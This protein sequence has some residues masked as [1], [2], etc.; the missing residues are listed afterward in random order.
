[1]AH[2]HRALA[3]AFA[4]VL[5]TAMTAGCLSTP[6]ASPPAAPHT[7]HAARGAPVA[8]AQPQA[9]LYDWH[10]LIPVPFGTLLKDMPI[11]LTEVLI[12]H[13]SAQSERGSED[14]DCYTTE[15]LSQPAF[16]G[17]EPDDH[18]L[19]FDHD[20]L[21]RIQISVSVP[22]AD[23]PALFAA[24]CAQ[25]QRGAAGAAAN[26]GAAHEASA[27]GAAA[28]GASGA[29]DSCTG[30]DGNTDFRAHLG[31]G[32]APHQPAA[33]AA[34]AAEA[35]AATVSFTLCEHLP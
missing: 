31:A 3:P 2:A 14:G 27:P 15:G 17:R 20:R 5:G 30:S 26:S 4:A 24:A 19:C 7:S 12:F 29:A 21:T 33:A 11:A 9:A 32:D 6:G 18:L 22:A 16:L 1:M 34:P 13:D 10:T 8:A 23:A 28:S 25:W 35:P